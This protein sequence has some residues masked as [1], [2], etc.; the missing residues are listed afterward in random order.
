[1]V[2]L[3]NFRYAAMK[4]RFGHRFFL[5]KPPQTS[6]ATNR[7]AGASIKVVDTSG[8]TL[9]LQLSS[10]PA[11]RGQDD[12]VPESWGELCGPVTGMTLLLR[13]WRVCALRFRK[14]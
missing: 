8:K 14:G 12:F 3:T 13:W 1:M 10:A 9:R 6:I 7:S 11:L 5:S 2:V 4:R